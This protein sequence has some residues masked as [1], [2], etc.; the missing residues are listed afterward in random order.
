MKITLTLIF[1]LAARILFAQ[2]VVGI[3]MS[4]CDTHSG[5]EY[6]HPIRLVSKDIVN[7]TLKLKI[8]L[9]PSP[10]EKPEIRIDMKG[11]SLIIDLQMTAFRGF[12]HRCYREINLDI[13]GVKDTSITI[14][15]K[16]KHFE[17]DSLTLKEGNFVFVNE[18]EKEKEIV[19]YNEIKMYSTKYIFPT[20]SEIQSAEPNNQT[21]KDSLKVGNWI[22]LNT[23]TNNIE[24][25]ANYVINEKGRSMAKWY[26]L[27]D[28]EGNI[29]EVCSCEGINQD[30]FPYYICI[31]HEEYVKLYFKEP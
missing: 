23:V 29:S 19:E 20:N 15:Q 10:P 5:A 2:E 7:D 14:Y 30:G 1:L 22:I 18:K 9:I 17:G 3:E 27:Y 4:N 13:I 6:M 11:D 26:V 12:K 28:Q 16:N 31:T 21:L 25:K 24:S 8:G